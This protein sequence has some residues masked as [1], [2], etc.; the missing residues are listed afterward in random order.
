[1]SRSEAYKV[2]SDVK[3]VKEGIVPVKAL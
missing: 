2:F 3:P 1:M